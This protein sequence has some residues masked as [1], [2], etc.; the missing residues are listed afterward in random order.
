MWTIAN[1]ILLTFLLITA[2]HS[3]FAWLGENRHRTPGARGLRR[4]KA[5]ETGRQNSSHA[6]AA[7]RERAEFEAAVDD[8]VT[9]GVP[10]W[11]ALNDAIETFAKRQ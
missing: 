8:A 5:R 7:A 2:G 1:G 10:R 6:N 3:M 9:D 11:K 4:I